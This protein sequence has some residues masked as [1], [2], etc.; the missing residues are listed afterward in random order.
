MAGKISTV[1]PLARKQPRLN[2]ISLFAYKASTSRRNKTF[3]LIV[4]PLFKWVTFEPKARGSAIPYRQ[5][6]EETTMTSRRPESR[7]AVVRKLSLSI[8]ALMARSFSI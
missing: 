7:E 3:R 5:D 6:T 8:S 4:M 1:S 2:S